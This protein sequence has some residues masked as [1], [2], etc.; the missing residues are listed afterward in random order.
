M[1][2]R[3][4]SKEGVSQ[5]VVHC[6]VRILMSVVRS[7]KHET[8]KRNSSTTE[9]SLARF[10]GVWAGGDPWETLGRPAIWRH[11][12]SYGAIVTG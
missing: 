6:G 4:M 12:E 11:M 8:R 7:V 2:R 1:C 3:L 10:L 5:E 9:G